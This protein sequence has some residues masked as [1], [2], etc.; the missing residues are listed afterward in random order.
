MQK[1][2]EN[3][4]QNAYQQDKVMNSI[5][6]AKKQ[7]FQKLSAELTKQNIKLAMGDLVVER[8][9]ATK[10]LYVKSKIYIPNDKNL[11]LFLLQ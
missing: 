11:Q 10:R 7:G 2:L 5:I 3:L 1:S 6:A 9:G 4:L 8:N